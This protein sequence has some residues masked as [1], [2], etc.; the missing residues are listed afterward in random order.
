MANFKSVVLF[1]KIM[2][3]DLLYFWDVYGVSLWEK[4]FGRSTAYS[5]ITNVFISFN[6]FKEKTM[7]KDEE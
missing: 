3:I 7:D 1:L 6:H 5:C 4:K 2:T